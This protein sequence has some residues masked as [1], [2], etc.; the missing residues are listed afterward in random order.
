MAGELSAASRARLILDR[1]ALHAQSL[2]FFHP[3]IDRELVL[4]APLPAELAE[5]VPAD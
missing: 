5:L 2:R 3:M 1:H 4:E